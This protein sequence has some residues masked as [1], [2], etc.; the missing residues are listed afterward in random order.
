MIAFSAF[1]NNTKIK[2]S[3]IQLDFLLSQSRMFIQ[4]YIFSCIHDDKRC[5]LNNNE[6]KVLKS[7]LDVI[8]NEFSDMKVIPL[9]ESEA[10]GMFNLGSGAHRLAVTGFRKN[11]T[12]YI[13][14]DLMINKKNGEIIS[15]ADIIGILVHEHGHH[16]GMTDNDERVLD[17]VANAVKKRFLSLSEQINLSSV[18]LP[19]IRFS[20]HNAFP[21]KQLRTYPDRLY[22]GLNVL[23]LNG[24]NGQTTFIYLVNNDQV[25]GSNAGAVIELKQLVILYPKLCATESYVQAISLSNLRWRSLPQA[26]DL[27]NRE[28]SAQADARVLCGRTLETSKVINTSFIISSHTKVVDG[29]LVLDTKSQK[30]YMVGDIDNFENDHSK[31]IKIDSLQMNTNVIAGGGVWSGISKLTSPTPLKIKGCYAAFT[32]K[33]FFTASNLIGTLSHMIY[34]C[35]IISQKGNQIE[36]KFNYPVDKNTK[37][38]DIYIQSIYLVTSEYT[39]SLKPQ[40]RP[41]LKITN[42]TD[43]S[44]FELNSVEPFDEYDN[45]QTSNG[46][47]LVIPYTKKMRFKLVFNSCE[48]KFDVESF[49]FKMTAH[50]A[51]GKQIGSLD[52]PFSTMGRTDQLATVVSDK[53]IGGKRVFYVEVE[54]SF[55]NAGGIQSFLNYGMKFFLIQNLFFST[56]DLRTY[57]HEMGKLVV[58]IK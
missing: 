4:R 3:E 46:N 28:I 34:D 2:H 57:V 7:I 22:R 26:N 10:N 27:E 37:T 38:T 23:S 43:E 58:E 33:D 56:T 41:R 48:Q 14:K 52:Y 5:G 25:R 55:V 15:Q 13:N 42:N 45:L 31:G 32:S 24:N 12:I 11:S 49:Y 16:T 17:I 9:W 35:K 51:D 39:A 19:N 47:Y 21:F 36:V 53:C 29:E 1:G 30:R 44:L 8:P 50:T 20:I 40:F 18:G 54:F 6:Y